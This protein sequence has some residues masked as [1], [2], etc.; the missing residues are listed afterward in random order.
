[1][2]YFVQARFVIEHFC[3]KAFRVTREQMFYCQ[4][5]K[6]CGMKT[7]FTMSTIALC[8]GISLL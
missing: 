3:I 8:G 1:M 5:L 4:V 6:L 7:V 2:F